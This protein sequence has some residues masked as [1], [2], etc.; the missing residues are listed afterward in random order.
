MKLINIEDYILKRKLIDRR[1]ALFFGVI[2]GVV[3][4]LF[5]VTVDF[6]AGFIVGLLSFG[7]VYGLVF[8][9]TSLQGN[10]ALK[11]LK[12]MSFGEYSLEV[13]F[14]NNGINERGLLS[15]N[16][17]RIIYQPLIRMASQKAF[18]MEINPNLFLAYGDV[19]KRKLHKYRFGDITQS[20]VTVRA[21]P[22]GMTYQF[23][24]Y[25]IDDL[26]SRVGERL[27]QISKFQG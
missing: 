7:F 8:L 24:F 3:I 18:E 6:L 15:L 11:K 10:T 5:L 27:E 25:N 16:E 14:I 20:H 19:K 12:E 17:D 21:M 9:L 26:E 22:H 4:F 13:N 2:I 23:V 1:Q